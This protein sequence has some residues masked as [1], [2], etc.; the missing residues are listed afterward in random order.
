MRPQNCLVTS[1]SLPSERLQKV[2][3]PSY[4]ADRH[5]AHLAALADHLPATARA[6]GKQKPLS[7]RRLQSEAV[8]CTRLYPVRGARRFKAKMRRART[9]GAG[10][11]E[12][13]S[14]SA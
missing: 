13:P 14:E 1:F 6:M 3:A 10:G 5:P 4:E 8:K 7:P 11:T 12:G 9:K 2:A